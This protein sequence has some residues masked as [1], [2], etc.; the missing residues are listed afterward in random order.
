MSPSPRT[1]TACPGP[2]RRPGRGTAWGAAAY[3]L[4]LLALVPAGAL[5]TARADEAA[6]AAEACTAALEGRWEAAREAA[7]ASVHPA[8]Q[9]LAW[10]WRPWLEVDPTTGRTQ[11]VAG[12]A[13]YQPPEAA[14]AGPAGRLGARDLLAAGQPER[15]T[16]DPWALLDRL[17]RDR[18]W[19]ETR[20]MAGLPE[21]GPLQ[22]LAAGDPQVA[23]ACSLQAY[24]LRPPAP[25]QHPD[26]TYAAEQRRK[27]EEAER[28]R[29]EAQAIAGAMAAV[30]LVLGLWSGLRLRPTT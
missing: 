29:A 3:A 9:D 12:L 17:W 21:Q 30:L 13:A 10:G 23:L 2:R 16:G 26:T 20:G 7:G 15:P 8:G 1:V 24:V 25:E 22:G 5:P 19:R 4:A 18:L 27:R 11:R 28:H 6:A 14:A